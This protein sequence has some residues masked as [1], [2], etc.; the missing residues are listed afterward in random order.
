MDVEIISPWLATVF[1]CKQKKVVILCRGKVNFFKVN[2][3]RSCR[4]YLLVFLSSQRTKAI[5][6]TTTITPIH[7][8]ALKTSPNTSHPANVP[9][10]VR[11][12]IAINEFFIMFI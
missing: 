2:L 6:A 8:P 3:K 10:T 1:S 12:S 4:I 7:I 11:R 5:M 9:D